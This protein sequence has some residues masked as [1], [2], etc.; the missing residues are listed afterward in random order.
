MSLF[1]NIDQDNNK[2]KYATSN[3]TT[4]LWGNTVF[5]VSATEKANTSNDGIKITHAGWV[6]QTIG[7]GG[8]AGRVFYETL[9]A[10]GSISGDNPTDNTYFPGI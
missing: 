4:G 3:T 7:T 6:A 9:V 10:N 5:G 8:R 1:G 2:P